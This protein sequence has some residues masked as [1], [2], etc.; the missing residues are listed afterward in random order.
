MQERPAI[1]AEYANVDRPGVAHAPAP[2]EPNGGERALSPTA[3]DDIQYACIFPLPTPIDPGA[4]CNPSQAPDNPLCDPAKPTRQL[5]A[6]AYPSIRELAVVHGLAGQGIPASICPAQLADPS[7][8][9][10]GYRPA[11]SALIDRMKV[12]LTETTCLPR[13]LDADANGETP[14]VVLEALHSASGQ[15]DCTQYPGRQPV[16]QAHAAVVQAAKAAATAPHA[17]F[18]WN[19]FCEVVQLSGDPSNPSSDV[20]QCEQVEEASIPSSVN[21]WCYVDAE[22]SP[23]LGNPSLS[24]LASCPTGDHR[25]VRFVNRGKDQAGATVI[26][27]CPSAGSG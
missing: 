8:A 6:K 27:S 22:A 18:D 4:D 12:R 21:G 9:D 1:P 26:L 13:R 3:P 14:C 10:F 11:I 7:K 5:N 19:S 17:P 23:P 25:L 24:D 2:S 15:V 20:Y 16:S